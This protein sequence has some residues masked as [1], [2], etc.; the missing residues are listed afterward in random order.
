MQLVQLHTTELKSN[1]TGIE[2][3]ESN[4]SYCNHDLE[5]TFYVIHYIKT[6]KTLLAK[7]I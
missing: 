4:F 1:R 3:L 2:K 7:C 6:Q 5:A